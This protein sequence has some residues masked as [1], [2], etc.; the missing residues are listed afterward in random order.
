AYLNVAP[1]GRNVEG[2][3]AAS[4]VYFGKPVG[5]LSLPEALTLA[6]I[7]QDPVRHIRTSGDG[8]VGK[9]LTAARDRLY[10]RW[11]EFHPDD[12]KLR[13]LFTLPFA[14]KP[15]SELPFEAPH[16]VEQVLVQQKVAGEA[17]G[18]ALATTI[19]LDLQHIVERQ[20]G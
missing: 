2:V 13:P 11:L 6:V 20:I 14:I 15:L 10:G 12:V 5:K 1:F 7:P 19:D 17:T 18:P 3:G 9:R 8:L 4:L 16:A